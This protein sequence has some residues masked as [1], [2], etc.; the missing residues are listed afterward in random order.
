MTL[1]LKQSDRQDIIMLLKEKRPVQL[2]SDTYKVS[3]ITIYRIAKSEG[4][5]RFKRKPNILLTLIKRIF[6]PFSK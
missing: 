3:R 5:L 6:M 4:L 2:I 1:K